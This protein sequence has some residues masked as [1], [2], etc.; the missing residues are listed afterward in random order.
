MG[1]IQDVER[2]VRHLYRHTPVDRIEDELARF[3]KEKA[4][5]SYKN[6]IEEGKKPE[7]K[8]A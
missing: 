6:G 7:K 8:K 5:E 2:E 3:V 4:L 1:Y